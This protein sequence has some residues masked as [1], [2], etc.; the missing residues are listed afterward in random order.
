MKRLI[1]AAA[2]AAAGLAVAGNW[3]PFAG[4]P[5]LGNRRLGT[6]FDVNVVTNGP[7]PYTMYF[8]WRPKKAIALV[9]S[10]DGLSWTQEPEICLKAN[11][12]SGWED[13]LNRSCTVYR[14][15]IWHM[16][17]TGQSKGWSRIGYAT[18]TDG[19]HFTRVRR[20][21]VLVPEHP[22]ETPSTMNP[23]VRWD[24]ARGV[25]RMWYAGG[26]QHEPNVLC[27]AESEDGL[28]WKKWDGNPFFTKGP[29]DSW[30]RD[31]V[32]ACEV[33][34][35]PDGRWAMFYIGYSDIDTAR[36][37]CAISADGL[38]DW[39]RLPQNP[40]VAPDLGTWNASACYKPSVVR[41]EKND[42]WLLWYNGRNGAPEYV[43]LA[44]HEGLDLE[45]PAPAPDETVSR[46]SDYVRRF[47]ADDVE[48]YTNAIPNAAAEAFLLKNVPRFACPD[49]DIERTYY[50]RWWT[51]R[52]HLRKGGDGDWR[53]TE[54][55]P[56]VSWSGAD[57]T[58][59]C[60][61]G[62][63]LREGR[64]L[65]DA[66]ILADNARFWLAD[67]S[68]THRW[69]YASW[70]FTGTE[71][72][73]EV[74]GRDTLPV[75]LLDDAV[76]YWERWEKGFTRDGGWPMGGDGKGG[77]LSIDNREGT[78]YSL[79]GNGYKPLFL[80]AMW[81]EA[82]TIA[83]VARRSG[84]TDLAER[85]DAKAEGVR[86]SLLANCW[87]PDV[88]FFT[89]RPKDGARGTVRELHGYAPW[90]FGVPTDGRAPDW[91]Q[92]ADPQG[93]AARFG[94][95][96]PERRAPGFVIDYKGHE[97]KWNGP[98][99][100]YATSVALTAFA[101]DLHTR[102][103]GSAAERER[104]GFLLWQYAAQQKRTQ[105]WRTEGD[106][107]VVPW[108]DENLHPDK[109]EWIAR[110]IILDTPAMRDRFPK[111]RGKDY[112]HSTFCDLVISG[113]VG[114]VPD[115]ARGFAVDPLCPQAWDWFVLED[116]RYRGHAV[117][118][119]W[120]RGEGLTV[121]VDGRVAA[122]RPTLGRLDVKLPGVGATAA[123][124]TATGGWTTRTSARS[125]ALPH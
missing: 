24:A 35:L 53:V 26:E 112:N 43:G 41:D 21:P 45:A 94:L 92:L 77:F 109:S 125:G 3:E 89:T 106:F 71:L 104:F 55:L 65:H 84:R 97:C 10:A 95:T 25:W 102:G 28:T 34:P 18:S 87:N 1:C 54:F 31:R 63:H 122:Q 88:G 86:Q 8:S 39:K 74:T 73:A 75:E 22:Y 59:V 121:T 2:L 61:A 23:Y 19:V 123:R 113:L 51:F 110:K 119:R 40:I 62:H 46:L 30:D 81:R 9:R 70:L 15:G 36:I 29:E 13:D 111:E 76:R 120:Q 72:L 124:P 85:F 67:P 82:R 44:V 32:G 50:F 17:Y 66:Q 90:Y 57:N 68:A 11:P 115:G 16:W 114:L 103:G 38:T 99:W 20:E 56:K 100:P 33:H 107:R 49:K 52:K 93:F 7:A 4:N 78:E 12:A 69:D 42:R 108:I 27:Y 105:D 58:I 5:V 116:V 83:A 64:W 117:S 60:P 48:L 118:V 37:G 47:N 96:F 98:S 91:G 79:G 6:C 101:N 14:D 80:S